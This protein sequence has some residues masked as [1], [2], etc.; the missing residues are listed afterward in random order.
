MLNRFIGFSGKL[1]FCLR[2]TK[3]SKI[4][5]KVKNYHKADVCRFKSFYFHVS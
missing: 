3:K 5:E 1:L 2:M 4:M